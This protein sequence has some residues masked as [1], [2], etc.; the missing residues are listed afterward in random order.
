MKKFFL[1]FLFLFLP[2]SCASLKTEEQAKQ[3]FAIFKQ[4]T[5]EKCGADDRPSKCYHE[6]LSFYKNIC[7]K[8]FE[9]ERAGVKIPGITKKVQRQGHAFCAKILAVK[10]L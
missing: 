5:T 10:T 1:T 8:A 6:V 9:I 7:R 3:D 4:K 2:L